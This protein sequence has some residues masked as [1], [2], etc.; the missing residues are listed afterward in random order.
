MS[1]QTHHA[2]MRHVAPVRAELGTRTIFNLLGPL[3]NPASVKRQVLGVF[4]AH[5]LEPLAQVLRNLGSERVWL[6]HGSDGLDEATTTG[7]TYVAALENG[8]IRSFE[9]TPEAAGL[10]RAR[11]AD[12]VGG[13]PAVHA[14]ALKSVLDGSRSAYRDIAVLNAAIALVIAGEAADLMEGAALA[15]SAIDEGRA[16]AVLA[17]LVKVSNSAHACGE[18][19]MMSVAAGSK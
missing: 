7:S 17:R 18:T 11:L 19:A 1:A 6:L 2:A 10:P 12:L 15:A 9:I 3:S 16:G 4:A 13:D 8:E 14:A 5:W